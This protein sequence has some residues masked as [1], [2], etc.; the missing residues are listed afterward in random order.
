M[1][2]FIF[3][4]YFGGWYWSHM[5]FGLHH[6]RVLRRRRPPLWLFIFFFDMAAFP[7]FLRV[8][9]FIHPVSCLV[10]CIVFFDL[11]CPLKVA[12]QYCPVMRECFG[13]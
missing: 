4:E 12:S 10:F 1:K 2:L 7:Y 8:L 6:K 9:F 13:I 3:F 5:V 11:Q